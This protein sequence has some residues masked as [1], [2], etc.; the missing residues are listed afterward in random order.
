MW[1]A[2][3]R[4]QALDPCLAVKVLLGVET[5]N[6]LRYDRQKPPI[7]RPVEY[8]ALGIDKLVIFFVEAI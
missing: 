1:E 4:Q 6:C 3:R 2:D 5:L 7:W 8:R